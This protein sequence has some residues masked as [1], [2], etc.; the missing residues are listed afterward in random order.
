MELL[1][2]IVPFIGFI[3]GILLYHY[4]MS[5]QHHKANITVIITGIILIVGIISTLIYAIT[6]YPDVIIE[7]WEF[8]TNSHIEETQK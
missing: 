8:L 4:Y 3:P 6:S 5:G 7:R 2:L 1:A